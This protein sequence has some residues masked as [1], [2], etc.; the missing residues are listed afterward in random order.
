M[1]SPGASQEAVAVPRGVLIGRADD[2][3]LLL[4]RRLERPARIGR[5]GFGF[6]GGV[7]AAAGLGLWFT[8]RALLGLAFAGFG[9]VL[10]GLAAVQHVLVRRDE[11]HWPDQAIL[12]EEGIELVLHNGEVRG[13]SW[14][15]PDLSLGLIARRAPR[16]AA[17]EYLLLWMG[18][19]HVPTVELSA[20][21]FTLVRKAAIARQL[22]INE[23]RR[24]REPNGS[25][26]IEIRQSPARGIPAATG[27]RRS[28]APSS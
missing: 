5:Y 28:D 26:W 17:R 10:L 25:E 20:A 8:D 21:G 13:V 2:A 19:S 9:G 3:A 16:P 11:A 6:I 4:R 22:L 14:D 24:G 1:P 18:D 23:R 27:A 7:I 15:D 12:W